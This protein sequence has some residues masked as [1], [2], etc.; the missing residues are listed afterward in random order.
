MLRLAS[1]EEVR[2]KLTG[3]ISS[4]NQW[5]SEQ[6][7]QITLPEKRKEVAI[8]L[9]QR[10]NFAS[11]RIEDG[12]GALEDPTILEAFRITSRTM[13]HEIDIKADR[14]HSRRQT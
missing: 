6:R 13:K 1:P 12:I 9:L 2:A 8:N 3:L 11:K 14:V 4:Y 7:A 10:A 5:I